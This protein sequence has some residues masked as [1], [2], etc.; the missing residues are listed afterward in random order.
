MPDRER[1]ISYDMTYIQNLKKNIQMNSQNINRPTD[2]ENKFMVTKEEKTA[3]RRNQ[4]FEINKYTLLYV[5]Q[6]NWT[7]LEF[8]TLRIEGHY[9]DSE[10]GHLQEKIFYKPHA[11]KNYM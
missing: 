9:Q 7:Q 3:G 11:N 6:I 4:E 1:Q 10:K 8:Q 2:T 5:K